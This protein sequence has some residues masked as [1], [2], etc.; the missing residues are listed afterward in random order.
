[1]RFGLSAELPRGQ[2]FGV[3]ITAE[4][5]FVLDYGN[6]P[7][8]W[9]AGTAQPYADSDWPGVLHLPSEDRELVVMP[10]RVEP[11][12][13]LQP[14]DE[15]VY[16]WERPEGW[17]DTLQS[18]LQ[19]AQWA[20][21]LARDTDRP[22]D[23]F[24]RYAEDLRWFTGASKELFWTDEGELRVR[25]ANGEEHGLDALSSGE[26]QVLL[27]TGEIRRR[28]RPGSL[29]LIDEPDLHL[30]PHW[31]TKLYERMLRL[32]EEGDAGQVIMATQSNHLF[33]IAEPGTAALIGRSAF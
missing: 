5:R 23:H 14:Q 11:P 6:I 12:G 33:R 30:H 31:E 27:L 2:N 9:L 1:R 15:F 7:P 32:V 3:K 13:P 4:G 19:M 16:R 26:K 28:M 8:D 21:F 17:Q 22:G 20:D 24:A 25:L 10:H 18:A 29:L